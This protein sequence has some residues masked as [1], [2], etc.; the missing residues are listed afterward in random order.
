L[1]LVRIGE[2]RGWRGMKCTFR[3]E[4]WKIEEK[5]MRTLLLFVRGINV[6]VL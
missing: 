3:F 4:I 6:V 2:E 5:K 1:D